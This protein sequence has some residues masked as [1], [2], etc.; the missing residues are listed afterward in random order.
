M[1]GGERKKDRK[2]GKITQGG[3][4]KVDSSTSGTTTDGREYTTSTHVRT[5]VVH[6]YQWYTCTLSQRTGIGVR[7]MVR[8]CRC[9]LPCIR[10]LSQLAAVYRVPS[11][12]TRGS[13]C[14]CVPFSNQ[15][16][17]T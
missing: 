1:M 2:K 12:N 14:T 11:Q 17:V 16:V 9:V 4:W 6:T 3:G 10:S 8:V 7:T 5:R 15:K 13:Q